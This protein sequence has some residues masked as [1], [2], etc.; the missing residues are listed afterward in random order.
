M[1]SYHVDRLGKLQ[2]G[3]SVSPQ[4]L[5]KEHLSVRIDRIGTTV[6][7]RDPLKAWFPDGLTNHGGAYTLMAWRGVPKVG[8]DGAQVSEIIFELI[9][10][11]EFE[12]R[13]SRLQSM[14]ACTS[15]SEAAAFR[16]GYGKPSNRIFEVRSATTFAGDMNL[17]F[18]GTCPA[19]AIELAR[20]YWREE[21]S[22]TPTVEVLL[23]PPV[24]VV[25]QVDP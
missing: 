23:G 18:C 24:T 3:Q 25:R 22:S 6:D 1:P 14:F 10:R 4:P 20:K 12:N 21:R 8:L 17:L 11:L 2:A 16:A 7:I 5:D 15:L 13:P 9:R 19:A